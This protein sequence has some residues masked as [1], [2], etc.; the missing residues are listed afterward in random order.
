M[1]VARLYSIDDIRIEEDPRPEPGPG[2][3]LV[4]TRVCGICTGDLMGWYMQRKAPLVFGHEPTGE[5]VALGDGV[6]A[7]RE[8]DRV[9]AHHHAPCGR[10]RR[11]QRGDYVHCPTWRSTSLR[12][13]GMAEYFIVPKE[14]LCADTLVLPDEVDFEAGALIEPLACV[15]KS[16][17]RAALSGDDTVVVVGLGIMGQLHVALAVHAG[18]RVI[19]ADLV[20]FRLERA[21]Q[22]GAAE[23]V[24]V[25]SCDLAERVA[26]LTD[27]AM[28]NLVIVGPGSLPAMRSGIAAAGAG[29]RVILFTASMPE[30]Q[31]TISPFRLYFDEVSLIPSYSCGP[32]DTRAALEL[33][34]SGALATDKL[35]T[36]RFALT[37]ISEAMKTAADVNQALKTLVVFD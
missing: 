11:C 26:E 15:V 24:D 8:G 29:A 32:D 34:R 3:A 28:A 25:S 22:L 13:G 1:R 17:R 31:L 5:V 33:L 19:A 35:V 36:H 20:P 30:D 16:M 37:Q 7:V 27:G 12:P 14:N 18:A 6:E 4:R 10:C 9:F 23:L 2:E 21:R